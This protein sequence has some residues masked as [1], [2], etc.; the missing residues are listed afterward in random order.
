MRAPLADPA[1]GWWGIAPFD[2]PV[3]PLTLAIL[4]GLFL[5]QRK[6]T[7]KVGADSSPRRAQ[8]PAPN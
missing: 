8:G 7:A 2:R 4:T 6:G 5:I 1:R 3:V